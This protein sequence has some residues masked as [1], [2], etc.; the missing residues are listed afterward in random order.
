M[1]FLA[2]IERG[3]AGKAERKLKLLPQ[4]LDDGESCFYTKSNTAGR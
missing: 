4:V 1:R 3:D 2:I